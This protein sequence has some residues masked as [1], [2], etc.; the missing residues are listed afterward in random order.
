VSAR[1]GDPE[2]GKR[3]RRRFVAPLGRPLAGAAL[4]ILLL[5]ACGEG[6]ESVAPAAPR[7]TAEPQ[8]SSTAIP[9]A[10]VAPPTVAPTATPE[11]STPTAV[12]SSPT[13]A[14]RTPTVRPAPS[15][16]SIDPAQASLDAGNTDL[17]AGNAAAAV[18]DYAIARLLSPQRADIAAAL[19]TAEAL[20]SPG[21]ANRGGPPATPTPIP[22]LPTRLIIPA[23][24]V[25]APVEHVGLATDGGMDV[26]KQWADVAWFQEGPAPGQAGNATIDGHL[27]STTAPAVFWR[28]GTL[29]PGDRVLVLLANEQTIAFTVREMAHYPYD[30]APLQR[31]F[32]P[33]T[34][35]DLNLITCGGS[36][37][38]FTK[39][40][41]ERVVAYTSRA[42][43]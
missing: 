33:S 39:N 23:I 9:T 8:A 40:Y 36:W 17:R 15:P 41:S 13:A 6:R 4:A 43:Q 21:Q 28:L 11:V 29:K 34:G 30:Q 5:A 10:T 7:A 25:N 42:D 31:I 22:S 27:D 26:P 20:L 2:H 37:D 14:P 18:H 38:A 12:P 16:T 19:A 3:G 24:G 32:G 35:I 1:S